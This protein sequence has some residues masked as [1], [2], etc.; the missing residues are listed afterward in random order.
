MKNLLLAIAVIASL[1]SVVQK[2]NA[3]STEVKKEITKVVSIKSAIVVVKIDATNVKRSQ[4]DYQM[5]MIKV[6]IPDIAK[7]TLMDHRN[8]GEGA[9]CMAVEDFIKIVDPEQIIQ[10]NP[11]TENVVLKVKLTKTLYPHPEAGKCYGMLTEDLSAVIRGQKFVHQ[12]TLELPERH[13]DDCK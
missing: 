1:Q 6:L 13:I 8:R 3:Q 2:A 11:G 12:R 4:A 10:N 9:P 5:P 7:H